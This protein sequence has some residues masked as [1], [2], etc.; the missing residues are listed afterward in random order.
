MQVIKSGNSHL[1]TSEAASQETKSPDDRAANFHL[2]IYLRLGV[3]RNLLFLLMRSLQ[4]IFTRPLITQDP[5]FHN[6]VH[7]DPITTSHRSGR[8]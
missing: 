3:C 4:H 6:K 1:V 7:L 2:N 8:L 5:S